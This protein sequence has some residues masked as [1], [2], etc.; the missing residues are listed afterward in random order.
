MKVTVA[1]N[2]EVEVV[3]RVEC[4]CELQLPAVANPILL[5]ASPVVPVIVKVVA[6]VKKR[7]VGVIAVILVA[8]VG[9]GGR[10]KVK[11]MKNM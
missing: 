11:I 8:V 9:Y 5:V 4:S 6:S 10:R 7:E 2:T 1:A 3:M